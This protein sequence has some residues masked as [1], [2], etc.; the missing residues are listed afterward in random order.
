MRV[1]FNFNEVAREP[2]SCGGKNFGR[3]NV[4]LISCYCHPRENGDPGINV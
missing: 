1:G 2:E 4:Y 3:H